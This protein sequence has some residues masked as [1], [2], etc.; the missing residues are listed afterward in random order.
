MSVKAFYSV[1][2]LNIKEIKLFMSN[3][4]RIY[5]HNALNW[6]GSAKPLDWW[7]QGGGGGGGEGFG[8]GE[9]KKKKK[10]KNKFFFYLL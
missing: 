3:V 8:G 6:N 1:V 5:S 10:K 9:K 4:I 7:V 2:P